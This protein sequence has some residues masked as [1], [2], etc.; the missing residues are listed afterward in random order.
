MGIQVTFPIDFKSIQTSAARPLTD[1]L[2]TLPLHAS[3]EHRVRKKREH[4]PHCKDL[5][6]TKRVQIGSF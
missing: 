4:V 6:C 1:F 2:R 5:W 3:L